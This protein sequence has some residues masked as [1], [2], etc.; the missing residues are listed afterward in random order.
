VASK[1]KRSNQP[2][3]KPAKAQRAAAPDN[4]R[5][6]VEYPPGSPFVRRSLVVIAALFLLAVFSEG[7]WPAGLTRIVYQPILLFCQMAALFPK[8]ATHS[9]E[10]RAQGYT[11]SGPVKEIDLRPYFPIHAD[12]KENRFSRAMHFVRGEPTAMDALEAYVMRE[13]NR[14]A[15]DKI[16]GVSFIGLYVPIPALGTPFSRNTRLPLSDFP[17]EVRHVIHVTPHE[18]VLRRCRE[19]GL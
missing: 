14:D 9:I 15:T 12:D 10:Y 5:E 13:Y 1:R 19:G 7:V 18:T 8:A 6:L 17:K 16:G 4:E 3:P 11:C 2:N